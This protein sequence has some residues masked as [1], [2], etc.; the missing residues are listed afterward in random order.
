M[1]AA[2]LLPR[3]PGGD[4]A[5][6]ALLF[7]LR[8]HGAAAEV[9]LR[10]R[11]GVHSGPVT[12]G[13]IGRLRARFCLFGDTVNTSSRLESAGAPGC[14]QASAATWAL[15]GLPAA[16]PALARSLQLK[17]KAAPLEACLLAAGSPEAAQAEALLEAALLGAAHH[18]DAAAQPADGEDSAGE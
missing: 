3:R 4:A 5:A 9:G 6:A 15:A 1:A 16:P 12:A 14:V 11:C 13:L 2:G 17:G 10:V 8:A 18:E 7:A